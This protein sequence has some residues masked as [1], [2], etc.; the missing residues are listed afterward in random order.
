LAEEVANNMHPRQLTVAI[1]VAERDIS[2]E[3]ANRETDANINKTPVM[4]ENA[5]RPAIGIDVTEEAAVA[6]TIAI[7]EVTYIMM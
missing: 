5:A 3:T 6:A 2:P 7:V 4:I 1:F